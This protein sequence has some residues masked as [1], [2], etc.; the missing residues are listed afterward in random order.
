MK[1]FLSILIIAVLSVF[2]FGGNA[3]AFPTTGTINGIFGSEWDGYSTDGDGV[4]GPGVGGQAYD[5]ENIGLFIDG[6]LVH[7][8]LK[9][10]FDLTDGL[11]GGYIAGDLA[12]NVDGDAFYEY[13][14]KVSDGSGW[15]VNTGNSAVT[16]E[17]W[18]VTSWNSVVIGS[19]QTASDPLNINTGSLLASWTQNNAYG[20]SGSDIDND[21][22]NP[23]EKSYVIEGAFARSLLDNLG[24]EATLHWTMGCGNDHL[25]VTNSPVPEPATMMLLGTGLIG[26]AGARRRVRKK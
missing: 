13:G 6:T 19:H 7:F 24:S 20:V 12:L 15:G 26:L 8:G 25:E 23:L 4:L 22:A 3:V 9:T 5:V 11:Y 17:L 18:E 1:K 16:Y 21:P 10:G 14:I 2:L